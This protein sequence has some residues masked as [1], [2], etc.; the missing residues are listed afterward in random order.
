MAG[1]RFPVNRQL[2]PHR[3][4]EGLAALRSRSGR[5]AV[6]AEAFKVAKKTGQG[7]YSAE[8]YRMRGEIRWRC[9]RRFAL[10][11]ADL[12][13][14]LRITDEQRSLS[15]RLRAA[16]SLL[17]LARERTDLSLSDQNRQIAECAERLESVLGGLVRQ[18]K[19]ADLEMA[20]ALLDT[21]GDVPSP[22]GPSRKRDRRQSS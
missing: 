1:Q 12:L 21:S 9:K 14:A 11:E 5:G 18:P 2:L 6:L 7:Y 15:F 4:R 16:T 19:S 3:G 22:R 17:Q 13:M 20:R 8:M 10:A